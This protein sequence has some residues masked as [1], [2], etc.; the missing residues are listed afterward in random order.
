MEKVA[1]DGKDR[2]TAD[3]FWHNPAPRTIEAAI[4]CTLAYAD[5]FDYPLTA[6]EVHR[7]LVGMQADVPT[8]EG[9]LKN[10]RTRTHVA[11]NGAYFTLSGRERIVDNRCQRAR[12]AAEGWPQAIRYGRAIA[13]LPFV[14]MVAVTGALA[15]DNAK[16]GDDID[17]LIVT[18]PGRLWLCRAIII[19][20]VVKPAGGRG[21]T[22]CPN[23]L[24]SE[25]A[26][27]QFEHN[28]FTAHEIVQM[29]P[30]SGRETYERLCELN[31]W[32]SRFLPNAYGQPRSLRLE[33]AA[34]PSTY[35]RAEP[36]LRSPLGAC[37]ERWEMKRKIGKFG[38]QDQQSEVRL[39]PDCC[40]A[41]FE[42]HSQLV[43]NALVRRLASFGE[44]CFAEVQDV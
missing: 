24:L 43:Q 29:V 23:Y 27:A 31:R 32:A 35:A 8:V 30:I 10:G 9:L 25:R 40:K 15:V 12:I 33:P 22:I 4:L 28:L 39:S 21:I 37:L 44:S 6:P 38:Q 14:R 19:Q 16:E 42:S 41:H 36:I 20:L 17:Y 26:L 34:L 2:S 3:C 18:T 1:L 5:L 7:Y 11:R 13:S